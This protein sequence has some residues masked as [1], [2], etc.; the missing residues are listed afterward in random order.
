MKA[1]VL[2]LTLTTVAAVLIAAVLKLK[3]EYLQEKCKEL[4]KL[5]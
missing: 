2:I 1:L 4:E 3:N 5:N